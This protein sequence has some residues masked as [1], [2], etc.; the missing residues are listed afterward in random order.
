VTAV[1]ASSNPS[2][3][4][5]TFV[6]RKLRRLYQANLVAQ[7]GI[8]VTGGIVR[9]TGSGLGCPTWPECVDGSITPTSVQDESTLAK[10]VE[11]GNRLLTFVLAALAIAAVIATIVWL[12]RQRD[13]MYDRR[14]GLLVLSAIPLVGTVIQAVV[15]GITVL[16]GLSPYAVAAHFL[17]SI[18]IIAGTVVLVVESGPGR[19]LL[20]TPLPRLVRILGIAM[21]VTSAVV[22]VLGVIVT[23]S[24]P[25]S[26]DAGVDSRFPIDPR[27][28]SWLHADAVWLF[29]GLLAGLIVALHVLRAPRALTKRVWILGVI[30]LAQGLIGYV[31]YFTGLPW[32]AVAFHMLGACLVWATTVWVL[33]GILRSDSSATAKRTGPQQRLETAAKDR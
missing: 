9:L 32:V 20:P 4:R 22:V 15:G 14:R 23:G 27:L 10:A 21:A 17:I 25:H 11:F 33:L 3:N 31:Q 29:L 16:T 12:R 13:R 19:I 7:I 2:V 26:G 8:V 1:A 5:G 6:P 24:G 18:A 30:S 28:I